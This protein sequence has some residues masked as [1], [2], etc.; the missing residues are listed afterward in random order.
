MQS[1]RK[2]YDFC[3]RVTNT[4]HGAQ[5]ETLP[6]MATEI[7]MSNSDFSIWDKGQLMVILTRTRKAEDTI[8]VGNKQETLSAL[9]NILLSKTQWTNFS[10]HVLSIITINHNRNSLSPIRVMSQNDFP[11]RI[12]DISLPTSQ[13]G[14]VYFLI[15][16]KDRS[17]TYI[18]ETI[19]IVQRLQQ[20]N[21]GYG[22]SSTSPEHL[23][24][25]DVMGYICGAQLESSYLRLYLERR[26]KVN[27][28]NLISRNN[29]DPRTWAREAGQTA[30]EDAISSNNFLIS[31]HD[32][33]LVLLFR[34]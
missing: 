11:F 9:K 27:S 4:I 31:E 17:F 10:E 34:V 3:H 2:Q 21:E 15:S 29:N 33:K 6:K 24:P 28:D 12:C 7:S 23:R 16:V 18:G 14:F 20:H 25:Y 26:W 19:C 22:S 32:L 30:I 13:T 5:G 1:K 8:F